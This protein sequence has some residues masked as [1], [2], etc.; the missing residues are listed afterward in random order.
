MRFG[1]GA[2]A[3]PHSPL[4]QV[5]ST[6]SISM[7]GTGTCFKLKVLA[8]ASSTLEAAMS[9]TAAGICLQ[10]LAFAL[11]TF[12]AIDPVLDGSMRPD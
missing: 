8:F 3:K 7:S 2:R 1:G 9:A 11:P 4:F 12:E 10:I 5:G 6:M